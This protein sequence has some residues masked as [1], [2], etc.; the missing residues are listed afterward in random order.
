MNN[1]SNHLSIEPEV[2]VRIIALL[3][4]EASDFERDELNRMIES[5]PE[6]AAFK[7]EMQNVDGLIREISSRDSEPAEDDWKLPSEK[8]KALLA[9]ISG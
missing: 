3:L 6:L 2:E 7:K 8:R 4:G 5:R 9:T 1:E